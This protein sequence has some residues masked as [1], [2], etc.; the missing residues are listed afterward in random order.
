MLQTALSALLAPLRGIGLSRGPWPQTVLIHPKSGPSFLGPPTRTGGHRHSLLGRNPKARTT[1]GLL[2]RRDAETPPETVTAG[3][4][5]DALPTSRP[6]A[7]HSCTLP[8]RDNSSWPHHHHN[9]PHRQAQPTPR[10]TLGVLTIR[11]RSNVLPLW[12][13]PTH[14]FLPTPPTAP[15]FSSPPTAPLYTLRLPTLQPRM[16]LPSVKYHSPYKPHPQR[17]TPSHLSPLPI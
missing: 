10:L 6:T 9:I 16:L 8:P 2:K 11:P 3:H 14:P 7:L 5:H 4:F 12:H 17:H 13:K 15:C 1:A